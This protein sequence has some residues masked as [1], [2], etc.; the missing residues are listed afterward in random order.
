MNLAILL[1]GVLACSTAVIMVKLSTENACLLAGYRLLLA[2]LFLL[3]VFIRD[4]RRSGGHSLAGVVRVSFVPG[5]FLGLH[6]VSWIIGARMTSAINS[7][8]IVNMMPVMMPF[9]LF[10]LVGEKV[11]KG[12]VIG[13][14]MA[15]TGVAI[16]AYSDFHISIDSLKGDVLCFVSMILMAF[17][18]IAARQN[19]SSGS[20]WVYIVPVY[21]IGGLL[22]VICALPFVNPVKAYSGRETAII[23]GLTFIPTITGHSIL[24]HMMRR[25]RGQVVAITNTSQFVFAGIMAFFILNEMPNW[26]FFL[27]ASILVVAGVVTAIR[28]GSQG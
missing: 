17:Y 5:V 12:E 24:N 18:L 20:L 13:T 19:R 23:L 10:M 16:L 7:S 4:F 3:P 2:A 28:S 9:L 22:C 15:V 21:F 8:L 11:N 27:P 26:L 6:F 25:L 1:M 14:V